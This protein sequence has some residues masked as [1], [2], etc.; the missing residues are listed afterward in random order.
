MFKV[1]N[2]YLLL[3]HVLLKTHLQSKN[4]GN[5]KIKPADLS[6]HPP[7][8]QH[9]SVTQINYPEFPFMYIIDL[10]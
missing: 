1:K 4:S 3:N 8:S 2:I 10:T 6:G 5:S 9:F 7:V